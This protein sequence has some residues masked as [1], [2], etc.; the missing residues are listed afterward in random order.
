MENNESKI[1]GTNNDLK[2][3]DTIKPR[4]EFQNP[5]SVDLNE[6]LRRY[7]S[8]V[9]KPMIVFFALHIVAFLLLIIAVATAAGG[10]AAGSRSSSSMSGE[11]FFS[12]HPANALIAGGI[13]V[14]I[15]YAIFGIVSFALFIIFIIGIVYTAD[16]KVDGLMP[17]MILFVVAL[18]A[19]FL[20][21]ILGLVATIMAKKN[22]ENAIA[23][24]KGNVAP[25]HLI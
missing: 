18:F 23:Q 21:T 9:H 5:R 4:Q 19:P 13:F 6:F 2:Q 3:V 20:G 1:S 16:K 15:S 25:E 7:T 14:T 8:R 12:G 24:A 17:S 11:E 22:I 10:V